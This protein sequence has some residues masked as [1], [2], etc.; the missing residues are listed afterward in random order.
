VYILNF[1]FLDVKWE[2]MN[3]TRK[4]ESIKNPLKIQSAA[5]IF[6]NFS[7]PSGNYM[8][9]QHSVTQCLYVF[10]VILTINTDYLPNVIHQFVFIIAITLIC[11]IHELIKI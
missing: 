8:Y 4:T 6:L 11:V 3:L 7:K 2:N 9:H 1:T 10:H 5:N